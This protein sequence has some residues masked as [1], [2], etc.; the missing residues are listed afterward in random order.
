[1]YLTTYMSGV[2]PELDCAFTSAPC[3]MSSLTISVWPERDIIEM[4]T[5]I[6]L[7]CLIIFHLRW[8]PP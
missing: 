5:K 6:F 2:L 7:C 3:A 8:R 4:L 1:M